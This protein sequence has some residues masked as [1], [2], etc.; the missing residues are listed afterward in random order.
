MVQDVMLRPPEKL[1]CLLMLGEFI[2]VQ[3]LVGSIT[4]HFSLDAF[5]T[6]DAQL[7]CSFVLFAPLT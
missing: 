6:A 7:L 5:P 3:A 2:Q 4:V 1:C